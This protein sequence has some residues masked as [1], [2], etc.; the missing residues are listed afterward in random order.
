LI[1]QDYFLKIHW[2][3][4]IK[5]YFFIIYILL[6]LFSGCVQTD[7]Q[8][9]SK[10]TNIENNINKNSLQDDPFADIPCVI[11]CNLTPTPVNLYEAKKL[12]CKECDL[13]NVIRVIDG[14][15]VEIDGGIVR[16]YGVNTPEKGEKCFLEATQRT[17]SLINE[18][19][20][21]PYIGSIRVEKS[22]RIQDKFGR[23]LFYVYT[24]DGE[25][26]GEIL[27]KDGLAK[28]WTKDGHHLDYF[29]E[30]DSLYIWENSPCG[31][32]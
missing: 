27:I 13:V 25:S 26:I 7:S 31:K 21:Q 1:I 22:Q 32:R 3:K 18:N 23:F 2:N 5:N 12:E 24:H 16:F 10:K 28:V 14:D 4:F 17:K 8:E 29:L 20:L 19:S 15:T 6:I 30:L 11:R 9:E